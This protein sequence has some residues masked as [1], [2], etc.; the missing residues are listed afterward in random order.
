MPEAPE[1]EAPEENRLGT[2]VAI[3]IAIVT[4]IGAIVAWRASVAEDVGGDADYAGLRAAASYQDALASSRVHA[5]EDDA[6]FISYYRYKA[7]SD[8]LD[9]IIEKASG[10]REKHLTALT[11]EMSDLSVA[12]LNLLDELEAAR[13]L[14]RDGRFSYTRD[15]GAR[16][17]AAAKKDNLDF[18]SQFK[19]AED[20][21]V[22]TLRLLV[23]VFILSLS[24]IFFTLVESFEG[25]FGY[26]LLGC[27]VLTMI[28]GTAYAVLIELGRIS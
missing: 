25:A 21:R 6:V 15:V 12:N 4:V 26:V 17:A 2:V 7:L 19:E 13:Y 18:E 16:M 9:K 23:A 24:L 5:Y 20:Y 11:K 14:K 8:G 10:E 27:G 1:S 22:K 3:L 28:G